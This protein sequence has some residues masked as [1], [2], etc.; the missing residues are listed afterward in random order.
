M[1]DI[2]IPKTD[3]NKFRDHWSTVSYNPT[4]NFPFSFKTLQ[5]DLP[6]EP[7][8]TEPALCLF[9]TLWSCFWGSTLVSAPASWPLK[10]SFLFLDKQRLFRAEQFYQTAF[11]LQNYRVWRA[12]FVSPCL[13]SLLHSLPMFLYTEYF[14]KILLI[15][16]CQGSMSLQNRIYQ[17]F[18]QITCL[19]SWLLQRWLDQKVTS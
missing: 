9:R 1:A 15:C 2:R 19:Y 13:S 12:S 7:L 16:A 10:P 11:C 18:L 8:G 17:G 6:S 4:G 14:L 3:K 5:L